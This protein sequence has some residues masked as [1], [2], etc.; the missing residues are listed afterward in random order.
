MSENT[1]NLDFSD[2]LKALKAISEMPPDQLKEWSDHVLNESKKL[3][4]VKMNRYGRVLP[5][6]DYTRSIDKYLDEVF[7]KGSFR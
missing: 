7:G 6:E 4:P 2:T 3:V 1:T 5:N